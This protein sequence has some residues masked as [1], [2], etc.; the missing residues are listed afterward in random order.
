M[1]RSDIG[2]YLGLTLETVSRIFSKLK[3]TGAIKLT[4]ARSI[5]IVDMRALEA[6]TE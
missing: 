4:A 3:D 5:E 6:M 2:D 1:Q